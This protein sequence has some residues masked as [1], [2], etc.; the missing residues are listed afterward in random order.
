MEQ[1]MNTRVQIM[2]KMRIPKETIEFLDQIS[3][4]LIQEWMYVCAVENMPLEDLKRIIAEVEEN[5]ANASNLIMTERLKFL[6]ELYQD[7]KELEAKVN[8]LH[9]KVVNIYDETSSLVKTLDSTIRN[10]LQE[11]DRMVEESIENH[12]DQ[13][14]EKDQTI[15][16][17]KQE[18]EESRQEKHAQEVYFKE[19]ND[20]LKA[21][22][23]E[24]KTREI[25]NQEKFQENISQKEAEKKSLRNWWKDHFRRSPEEE[26]QLFI[27]TVIEKDGYSEQQK[28]YLVSCLEEGDSPELIEKFASPSLSIEFMKRMR[29]IAK[30]PRSK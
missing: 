2:E 10:V 30:R 9:D 20:H 19:T 8:D 3:V 28:E 6:K 5:P 13:I 18:L 22:R 15:E 1:T 29:A 7:N 24:L 4:P 11:K 16:K 25:R 12:M 14:K 21:L 27:K 17:L 26:A 23:T